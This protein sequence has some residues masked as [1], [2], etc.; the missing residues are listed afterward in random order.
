MPHALVPHAL[1]PCGGGN[2]TDATTAAAASSIIFLAMH[3]AARDRKRRSRRVGEPFRLRVP[4]SHAWAFS[5]LRDFC[6]RV[7]RVCCAGF[8]VRVSWFVRDFSQSQWHAPLHTC[9]DHARPPSCSR[10]ERDTQSSNSQQLT[11]MRLRVSFASSA[12]TLTRIGS[13]SPD[14]DGVPIAPAPSIASCSACSSSSGKFSSAA[15]FPS[16]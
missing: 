12:L 5:Q 4:L 9:S 14:L 7:W 13:S 6:F 2:L 15:S 10:Q 11:H 1:D 8:F 16:A 3:T